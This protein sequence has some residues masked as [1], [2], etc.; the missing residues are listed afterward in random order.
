ML[1][2][3]FV[4]AFALVTEGAR[5]GGHVLGWGCKMNGKEFA[6]CTCTA[7]FITCREK[8]ISENAAPL[9]RESV[10]VT[11][12]GAWKVPVSSEK[13]QGG[14]WPSSKGWEE[15]CP[16]IPRKNPVEPTTEGDATQTSGSQPQE[17]AAEE[18]PQLQSNPPH[19]SEEKKE[20]FTAV[21][22]GGP[23]QS[24]D[25]TVEQSEV[26][27]SEEGQNAKEISP[28]TQNENAAETTGDT[29]D[30][31]T[32][33]GGLNTENDGTQLQ[34][35]LHNGASV[36]TMTIIQALSFALVLGYL[37]MV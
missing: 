2:V 4:Y 3:I 10:N 32:P 29:T 37:S 15:L 22:V 31:S 8:D 36:I 35:T 1:P 25:D 12:E 13:S 7:D 6:S 14:G 34:T 30:T 18:S 28:S 16:F 23:E 27:D 33:A 21:T 20:H 9:G 19:E 24:D 11:C 26:Q 17:S 5:G